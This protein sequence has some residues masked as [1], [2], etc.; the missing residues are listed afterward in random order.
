MNWLES[1]VGP[2]FRS[3]DQLRFHQLSLVIFFHKLKTIFRHEIFTPKYSC[4]AAVVYNLSM[5][6]E[7]W[8]REHNISPRDADLFLR[9]GRGDS[10]SGNGNRTDL[11]KE[12]S[13]KD[14]I[15][16]ARDFIAYNAVILISA[17]SV[18]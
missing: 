11:N 15:F 6:R 10:T 13:A 14:V 16:L 18:R 12:Q 4:L 1:L 2:I 3:P 17:I 5:R 9:S 8:C 7:I